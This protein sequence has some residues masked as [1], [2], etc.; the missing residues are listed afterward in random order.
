MSR[1]YID[2]KMASRDSLGSRFTVSRS[3]SP[4]LLPPISARKFDNFTLSVKK[5]MNNC[6]SLNP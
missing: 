6:Y 3:T 4:S 2:R 5:H 1:K